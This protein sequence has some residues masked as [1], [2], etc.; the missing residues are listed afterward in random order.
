ML[1]ELLKKAP[2]ISMK[3]SNLTSDTHVTSEVSMTSASAEGC[4]LI[5]PKSSC[6]IG[7]QILIAIN[8]T[9]K[10]KKVTIEIVAKVI[11][12]NLIT[13]HS[14]EVKVQLT[15]YLRDEWMLLINLI[16]QNQAQITKIIN[17]LKKPIP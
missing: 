14:S 8:V 2:E 1:R 12:K 10:S 7:H 11:E 16:E 9:A 4:V 15:Q 3:L 13:D 17:E 5:L 6:S